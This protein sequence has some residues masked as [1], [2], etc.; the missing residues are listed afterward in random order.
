MGPPDP[1]G[2][3]S[4]LG[5][6]GYF[7]VL[8]ENVYLKLPKH[9]CSLSTREDI[10]YHHEHVSEAWRYITFPLYRGLMIMS[11]R[12]C[13][14]GI[15][16]NYIFLRRRISDNVPQSAHTRV[17]LVSSISSSH[18]WICIIPCLGWSPTR[19]SWRQTAL[20]TCNTTYN[21]LWLSCRI[22]LYYT[23]LWVRTC[24]SPSTATLHLWDIYK[25]IS[26]LYHTSISIHA[27]SNPLSHP[28]CSLQS[29]QA[30][31]ACILWNWLNLN[32]RKVTMLFHIHHAQSA[33]DH[34]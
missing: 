27:F 34:N 28:T 25:S 12:A 32:W 2:G 21:V 10:M 6:L 33:Q 17:V 8:W 5:H 19:S 4:Y 7:S 30:S 9:Q 26:K 16:V 15:E 13:P 14:G 31:T 20:E 3:Q 23:T 18:L 11:P 29:N 1:L 22:H 24:I